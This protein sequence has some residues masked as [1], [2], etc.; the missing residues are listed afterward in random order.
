M[1]N[2]RGR[3]IFGSIAQDMRTTTKRVVE[4]DNLL[5]FPPLPVMSS[6]SSAVTYTFVYTD[7]EPDRAFWEA[8]DEEM[9][10]LTFPA[11]E[12]HYL[13]LIP[14]AES[15]GFVTES[16]PSEDL[17]D[18][19]MTT[20]EDVRTRRKD[21][22]APPNLLI[23]STVWPLTSIYLQPEVE[24]EKLWHDYSITFHTV[25]LSPPSARRAPLIGVSFTPTYTFITTPVPSPLLPSIW[26]Y[27]PML[28]TQI[29]STLG[30][31]LTQFL[32]AS[33]RYEIGES[34]T[35]RPTRGRGIDYG[36]VSTVD[37]EERR[38]ELEMSEVNTRVTELAE[39]HEHDTQDLYAL[40]EDAQDIWMWRREDYASREALG[41]TR[42]GSESGESSE[43]SDPIV[44]CVM[45]TRPKS[46]AQ[47]DTAPAEGDSSF[48][49]N[50]TYM[51]L[52]FQMQLA[53]VQQCFER[54]S[55][56]PGT[57]DR[58]PTSP[59]RTYRV[60]DK[61]VQ[62][63]SCTLLGAALTWLTGMLRTL[64]PEAYCNDWEVLKKNMTDKD[65]ERSLMWDLCPNCTKCHLTTMAWHQ[66]CHKCNKVGH[67]ARDCRSTGNTNVANTQK[68]NGAAHKGNGCF[69][70]GAPGHF[71]RDCPKLKN[72][73]GKWECTRLG[74]C[75]WECRK[76][77]NESG[78]TLMPN[79]HHG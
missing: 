6:A 55:S 78:G 28:D 24:V 1:L 63:H 46:Q 30:L 20:D 25:S 10:C 54:W 58:F 67:F 42:W 72:K 34:S 8:D 62:L 48:R 31:S 45:H 2:I 23:L 26:V 9:M 18:D 79:V 11:E 75:S 68:G 73:M 76:E 3:Y 7:S 27:N 50:I 39:L 47:Q 33:S 49:H 4:Q 70:C 5:S 41:I 12:Q 19:A 32:A 53:V 36:F 65:W 17:E 52:S 59:G 77:R 40:L 44:S 66:R 57:E 14:H 21:H 61:S 60:A 15:P 13:L 35:A 16:D 56:Q 38:Q 71:K 51:R 29:A 74:L 43:L 37:A 64:G 22:L 69:E